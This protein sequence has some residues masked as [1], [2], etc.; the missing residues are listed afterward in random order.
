VKELLV[1]VMLV[2]LVAREALRLAVAATNS[3]SVTKPASNDELKASKSVTLVEKDPLSV[4]NA[5]MSVAILAEVEVNEPLISVAICAEEDK[6]PP[7][8]TDVS[9]EVTLVLRELL[10]ASKAP[11]ISVA[12]CAEEESVP[13]AVTPVNPE[14]S[15]KKDPVKEPVRITPESD[16]AM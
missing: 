13:A 1:V 2:I 4:F 9:T 10:A 15:P 6:R 16:C 14:P 11:L 3:A 7:A 8:P 12:I 5:A